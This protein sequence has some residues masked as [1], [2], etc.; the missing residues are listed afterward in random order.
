M[1]PTTGKSRDG[2]VVYRLG[3]LGDTVAAL[4]AF[5]AVASAFPRRRR[6]LL[7][8]VTE[9]PKAPTPLSVLGAGTGFIDH[10][11]LYRANMRSPRSILRLIR[12]LRRLEASTLVY[13][14]PSRGRSADRRDWIFFQLAGF[15]RIIGLPLDGSLAH[16][17]LDSA[18]DVEQES[19]RLARVLEPDLHIDLSAPDAWN[20]RLSSSERA[21]GESVTRD[22]GDRFLAVNMGGKVAANDWGEENWIQLAQRI[23]ARDDSLG[24][25]V[26]GGPFDRPRAEVLAGHWSGPVA[27]ACE[28]TPRESAAA[29]SAA[30][31]FV[32]HDSGP[33][34]LAASVGTPVLGLFGNHN[35]PR[36]WHP[37]GAHVRVIHEMA[38]TQHIPVERALT[39]VQAMLGQT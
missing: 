36:K 29:L 11:E 8:N 16:R 34:H 4:P 32:G 24:L 33:L 3:S 9:N 22:L 13:L 23:T 35:R 1:T 2:V 38:G 30:T 21:V 28:L 5:H 39:E 6:I 12:N 10:V 19:V 7:T 26:V 17:G 14:M 25:L 20:L 31:A 18:D 27:I 37:Y 15:R